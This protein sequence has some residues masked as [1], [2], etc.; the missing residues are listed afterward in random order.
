MFKELLMRKLLQSKLGALPKE[1]QD[2]IIHVVTK[3][4]ELFQEIAMKIKTKMDS[5]MDQMKATMSVMEEY[6]DRVQKLMA[7]AEESKK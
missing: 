5:G 3:N 1:E 4:P 2:K 6:K 7:E